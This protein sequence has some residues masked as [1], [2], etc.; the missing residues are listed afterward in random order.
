MF[1]I[2]EAPDQQRLRHPGHKLCSRW[3]HSIQSCTKGWLD[4]HL[5][6]LIV[7]LFVCCSF[8]LSDFILVFYHLSSAPDH[9]LTSLNFFNCPHNGRTCQQFLIW[10]VFYC[11]TGV[12]GHTW[13]MTQHKSIFT[14]QTISSSNIFQEQLISVVTKWEELIHQRILLARAW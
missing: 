11:P 13:R 14:T 9:P 12:C 3:Y 1:Y 10:C 8:N 5:D 6:Y 4:L 7:C 2:N